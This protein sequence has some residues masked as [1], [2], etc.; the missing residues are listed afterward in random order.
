MS[1]NEL[2]LAIADIVGRNT[3]LLE[4]RIDRVETSLN[5]K[6]DEVDQRLSVKIDEVDHRLSAKIDE[7]DHRL[8]AKI[9]EVDQRLSAKIDEV[10]QRLS[11]KMDG[12]DGRVHNIMLRLENIVEPRLN[13]IESC[14]TSTYEKYRDGSAKIESIEMNVAVLQSVVKEY[15]VKL[16]LI[17]A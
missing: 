10:D 12:V 5:N 6:I 4:H 3:K 1:D 17:S 13:N 2:L 11:N 8:S 14:Y 15:G 16:N 9:D 7:V